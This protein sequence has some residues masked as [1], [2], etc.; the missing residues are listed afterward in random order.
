MLKGIIALKDYKYEK[1]SYNLFFEDALWNFVLIY[2][3][4]V[5]YEY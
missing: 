3:R 2:K 5:D 4:M 1:L